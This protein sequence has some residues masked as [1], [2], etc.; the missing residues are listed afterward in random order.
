MM[1]V[2]DGAL[3][4]RRN[5]DAYEKFVLGGGVK[6]YKWWFDEFE[7]EPAI[8]LS[9]KEIQGIADFD[10]KYAENKSQAYIMN[11]LA[12]KFDFLL[13]GL[14]LDLDLSYSYTISELIDTSSYRYGWRGEVTKAINP[15]GVGLGEVGKNPN[16]SNNN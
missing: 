5:H 2:K 15:E 9:R 11:I 6:S 13:P 7:L 4:V 10:V 16:F 1:K 3:R 12:D 14:D 8:L